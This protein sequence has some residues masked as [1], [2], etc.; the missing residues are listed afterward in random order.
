MPKLVGVFFDIVYTQYR[1]PL[2]VTISPKK[3]YFITKKWSLL[4]RKWLSTPYWWIFPP[5]NSYFSPLPPHPTLRDW[6]NLTWQTIL[7]KWTFG[8]TGII[9]VL[10]TLQKGERRDGNPPKSKMWYEGGNSA[11]M[12]RM[13]VVGVVGGKFKKAVMVRSFIKQWNNF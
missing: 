5:N 10:G 2:K 4:P 12:R 11:W 9:S 3:Q 1:G 7:C 6:H 8:L 13:V